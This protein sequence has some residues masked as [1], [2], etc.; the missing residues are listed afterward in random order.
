MEKRVPV[1]AVFINMQVTRMGVEV[2]F[3]SVRE[4][5]RRKNNLAK[6]YPHPPMG[7]EPVPLFRTVFVGFLYLKS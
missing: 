4:S 1:Q 6:S 7:E 3:R 2:N 5:E